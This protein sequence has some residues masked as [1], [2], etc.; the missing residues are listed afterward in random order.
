MLELFEYLEK[1]GN[2][3]CPFTQD[4]ADQLMLNPVTQISL[5]IRQNTDQLTEKLK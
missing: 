2:V 3:F 5:V 1:K 4:I